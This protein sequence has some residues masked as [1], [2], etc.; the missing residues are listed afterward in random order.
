MS[1]VTY[2][3]SQQIKISF[4]AFEDRLIVRANRMEAEPATILLS[5]RMTLLILQQ[6]LKQLTEMS[7]LGKTPREYWH[8]VLQMSHQHAMQAKQEQDKA[9]AE[10]AQNGTNED[11]SSQEALSVSEQSIQD[12]ALYL[13]TELTVQPRDKELMLALK[14]LPMPAAMTERTTHQPILAIPLQKENVHQ[15][16]ELLMTRA[17]DAKWDL[18]LELPWQD[19]TDQQGGSSVGARLDN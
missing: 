6:L 11:G 16:I 18:P 17:A 3:I 19:T 4:S 1:R 5:R 13:A 14:G 15:M 9:Q 7:E 2:P 8:D 10:A 12:S